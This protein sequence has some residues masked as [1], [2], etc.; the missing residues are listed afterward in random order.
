MLQVSEDI[1][2]RN[3]L[4]VDTI[5]WFIPHQANLRIIEAIADRMNIDPQKVVVTIEKYGNTSAASIPL[6]LADWGKKTR[7]RRQ[8][9]TDF[10][11]CR[12]YLGFGFYLKWGY[13]PED[14]QEIPETLNDTEDAE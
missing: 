13:N 4:T 14:V 7:K 5:D 6:C 9:S 11:R 10:V 3:N 2:K 1:L 12:I 8:N